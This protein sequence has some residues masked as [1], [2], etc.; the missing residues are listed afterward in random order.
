MACI[1]GEYPVK[2]ES[3][4]FIETRIKDHDSLSRIN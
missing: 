1:D 2:V 3:E 4:Q